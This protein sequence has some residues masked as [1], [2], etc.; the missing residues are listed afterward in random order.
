MTTSLRHVWLLASF[1]AV[2]GASGSAAH[3]AKEGKML[4]RVATK[5]AAEVDPKLKGKAPFVEVTVINGPPG[6]AA[7]DFQLVQNEGT[8]VA[9]K[10]TKLTPYLEG[11]EPIAIA[12][13]LEGHEIWMGNESYVESEDDKYVGVFSKLG[14]VVA[15]LTKAGP[16]GSL[17]A[18]IYYN[19]S[20]TVKQGMTDLA[21][22]NAGMLGKQTDFQ[23]KTTRNFVAGLELALQ[24]LTKAGTKRKALLVIGDGADTNADSARE[25][26]GRLRDKFAEAGVEIYVVYFAV[27]QDQAPPSPDI[28][29]AL[30]GNLPTAGSMD[31]I[32]TKVQGVVSAIQNQRYYLTFPGYDDV[33]K[34]GFTWDG[35][36]HDLALRAGDKEQEINGV[37]LAPKW[38][39]DTGGGVP[40]WL[41]VIIP[42][43][44]IA[45]VVVGIK[46]LGKKTVPMPEP[47]PVPVAQAQPA[48]PQRTVMMNALGDDGPPVVG[49]IVPLNGPNQF[50]TFKLLSGVTKVGTGGGSHIVIGDGY[51]STEHA[52]FVAAGGGFVLQ[53]G[54]STNGS[55]VN[56]RRIDKHDLVDNDVIMMGKT[57]FKFKTT[58]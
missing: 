44:L 50:Q 17:G 11:K 6:K 14:A 32:A 28:M 52:Q 45:L 3:A 39:P 51:M 4:L 37:I 57:N 5:P 10:A 23:G 47:L 53:D 30:A 21:S 48:Q 56:E 49:W 42:L 24:E 2:L 26:M 27:S 7:E 13:L 8:P 22:L 31:D 54:G 38:A 43:L 40:W 20:A 19:T 41:F 58:V 55:Y 46:V 16:P 34:V 35:K 18:I 36:Q 29:E 33:L 1:V 9:I 12:L 15:A 25:Q